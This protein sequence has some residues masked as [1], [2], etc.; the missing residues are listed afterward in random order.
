MSGSPANS[1]LN[2][3]EALL[4]YGRWE[5]ARYLIPEEDTQIEMTTYRNVDE[6]WSD[7]VAQMGDGRIELWARKNDPTAPQEK[8]TGRVI[9]RLSVE[10]LDWDQLAGPGGLKLYDAQIRE[11]HTGCPLPISSSSPA[12][13]K[14]PGGRPPI[15]DWGTAMDSL[16]VKL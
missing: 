6:A 8:I 5:L 10:S 14:D 4:R 1:D 7:V 11:S 13:N 15:Y 3:Q 2:L 9:Y 12:T 16:M